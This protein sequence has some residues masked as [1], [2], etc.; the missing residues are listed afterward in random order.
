MVVVHGA[1]LSVEGGTSAHSTVPADVPVDVCA[2]GG[3]WAIGAPAAIE[4]RLCGSSAAVNEDTRTTETTL[5]P[6]KNS[7][8][9]GDASRWCVSQY[10]EC[11]S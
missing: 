3:V 6:T 11:T 4:N 5:L 2:G 8:R 9:E 7:R 1:V 10:T